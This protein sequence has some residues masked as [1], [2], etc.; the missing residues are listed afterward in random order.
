MSGTWL[1]SID[2]KGKEDV[3]CTLK[4]PT[5]R[6]AKQIPDRQPIVHFRIKTRS[7]GAPG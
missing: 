3:S 2:A 6:Y 4:L 1:F 7:I 5:V